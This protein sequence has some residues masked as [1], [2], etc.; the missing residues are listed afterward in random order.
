MFQAYRGTRRAVLTSFVLAAGIGLPLASP[1]VSFAAKPAPAASTA[2]APATMEDANKL[3][4][5]E[6]WTHAAEAFAAVVKADPKNGRAWFRLGVCQQR[7]KSY[8]QAIASYRRAEAI[9]HNPTVM[10]N[11]A[12]AFSLAGAPDSAFAWLGRMADAGYGRPEALKSDAD[13]ASLRGDA[14]FDATVERLQ[15]IATPCAFSPEARQ[16]DF[17]IGSWDVRTPQGDLAG[18]ND[19]KPGAGGCVLVENW[20]SAQGGPGQSLNFYDPDAKLWR[21]IWVDSNAQVTRFEGTFTEGQMRFHGERVMTGGQRVPV[22]MTFTPL[23]DGRVRQ[24]GE[25]SSDGGKSW[26]VEYDL[27]YSPARRDG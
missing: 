11:L 3:Y 15:R 9:A 5:A 16:F 23:P 4:Q 27:Y 12:C 21:Q 25:S 8:D 1:S 10:Y 6:D 20:K 26:S 24:M 7:L 14:R 2:A 22:K 17:W 13:L 19:V 18:T